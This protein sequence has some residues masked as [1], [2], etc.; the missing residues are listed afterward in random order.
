MGSSLACHLLKGLAAYSQS[1]HAEAARSRCCQPCPAA[2]CLCPQGCP[3]CWTRPTAASRGLTGLSQQEMGL[4][5]QPAL[6]ENL[7]VSPVQETCMQLTYTTTPK[8]PC[9]L[10]TTKLCQHRALKPFGAWLC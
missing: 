3:P 9:M 4:S 1:L 2:R 6:Q 5:W 10:K 8:E 7:H